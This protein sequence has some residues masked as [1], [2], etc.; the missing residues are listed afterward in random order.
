MTNKHLCAPLALLLLGIT[1]GCGGD[2]SSG[3]IHK[4]GLP[5]GTLPLMLT[6]QTQWPD[7]Q[8]TQ[9]QTRASMLIQFDAD[10]NRDS[11][12][13]GSTYIEERATVIRVDSTR[14]LS[15]E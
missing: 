3:G 8:D 12:E 5:K 14:S 6:I 10:L 7:D 4:G 11:L 15:Y 13:D 9:V 2:G 1:T